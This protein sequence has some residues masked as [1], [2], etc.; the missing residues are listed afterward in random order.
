MKLNRVLIGM[1]VTLLLLCAVYGPG[2]AQVPTSA[3]IPNSRFNAVRATILEAIAKGDIPSMSVAVAQDGE[4]IWE[5]AFGWADREGM[6]PATPHTMYSMASISKPI[7]TTGLMILVERGEVDLAEPVNRY[8]APAELTAFEGEAS[9]ATVTHILNHTSGLPVH[10][11]VFYQDEPGRQPPP[12]TE[13]VRRYGILVHPPGAGYQYANFGFALAD[14]I[15]TSVSGRPYAEFMKTEVFLPLGMNHTSIDVG[16]GLEEY[17]AVRYDGG[18]NP[19]PFYVSDHPGASQ[20]FASAHDLIRFGLFHLGHTLPEQTQ[21][22]SAESIDLMKR[23]SDPNPENDRYGL[24]WFLNGD[25][26]GYPIAWHTGSMRG[27]NTM[28]KFVPGEDIAVVVL[29]NT[30]SELRQIIPRDIIGVLL[31]DYG[32]RWAAQRD[33]SRQE[34]ASFEPAP[35][36]IGEWVG[37]IR[38]YDETVPVAITIQAD[39]DVKIKIADQLGTLIDRVRFADGYLSGTSYG[40]IPSSDARMHRHNIGYRMFLE[41]DVLSGYVN[42]QFTANRSYGNFSSYI[43]VERVGSGSQ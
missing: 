13:S 41:G 11:S 5:E 20:V 37:E 26:Y 8:I 42:T 28:L 29:V 23:D 15:I 24:G 27:T 14:H 9:A 43:R 25:E 19:V 32:E 12:F 33:R 40:T 18:G 17:A 34:R 3:T 21:I 35:E 1:V 36:L 6:T 10:Y 30:S 38:T 16:P 7:T 31:P 39:G 22:I 4:I 2:V